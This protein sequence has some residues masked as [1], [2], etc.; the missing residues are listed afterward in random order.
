VRP[1]DPHVREQFEDEWLLGQM[2]LRAGFE[3]LATLEPRLTDLIAG[4]PTPAVDQEGRARN[5]KVVHDL[6]EK[7][8]LVGAWTAGPHPIL[9]TDLAKKVVLDY[10]NVLH[11]PARRDDEAPVFD[12][13]D[14]ARIRSFTLFG[15][16][17]QRPRAENQA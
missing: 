16:G 7:S 14:G 8:E 5:H 10:L 6:V 3:H 11:D 13:Q 12:R 2:A 17:A 15:Q 4:V 9:R 1:I